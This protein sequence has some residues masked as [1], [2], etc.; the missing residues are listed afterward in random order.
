[1]DV[2]LVPDIMEESRFR[3]SE[4][5]VQRTILEPSRDGVTGGLKKQHNRDFSNLHNFPGTCNWDYEVRGD[6]KFREYLGGKAGRKEASRK[7]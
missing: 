1:M 3:V 2:K 7:T 4:S 6:T 5:S